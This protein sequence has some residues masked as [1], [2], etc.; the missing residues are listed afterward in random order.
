MAGD[1]GYVFQWSGALVK[2]TVPDDSLLNEID[3]WSFNK[4]WRTNPFESHP[5]VGLYALERSVC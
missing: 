2:A 3:E 5:N 4:G 1:A